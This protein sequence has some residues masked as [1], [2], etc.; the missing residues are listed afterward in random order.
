MKHERFGHSSV[1]SRTLRSLFRR[2]DGTTVT[3][4]RRGYSK[5]LAW[6]KGYPAA[7]PSK[8]ALQAA[9]FRR[10]FLRHSFSSW[11][12]A[13]MVKRM[14]AEFALRQPIPSE[15][16]GACDPAAARYETRKVRPF[17]CHVQNSPLTFQT[18]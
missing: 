17:Q 6:Q 16:V 5:G 1:T 11:Q 10:A 3:G 14:T 7:T 4:F 13:A 18:L 2:C 12:T 8:A 9:A 15:W